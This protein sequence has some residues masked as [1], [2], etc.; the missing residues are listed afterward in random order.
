M[1][2]LSIDVTKIDK[3]LLKE[4]IKKDG[5]KAVFLNFICWPNKEGKDKYDNDG[6]VK[7]SLS[8]EQRDA[9]IKSEIIGNYK[10]KD[11]GGST[12]SG[13]GDKIKPAKAFQNR[14][15]PAPKKQ[16]VWG[17]DDLDDGPIPF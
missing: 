6:S 13:W 8:K 7:H 4:V 17:D 2:T 14:E 16:D 10:V 5:T 12:Q 9:G 1:F 11:E 3:S 15:K